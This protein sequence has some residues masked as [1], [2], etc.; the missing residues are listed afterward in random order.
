MHRTIAQL[1]ATQHFDAVHADQLWMAQYAVNLPSPLKVLDQHNAVWTIVHRMWQNERSGLRRMVMQQEWRA[2]QRYEGRVCRQFHRVLTVTEEDRRALEILNGKLPITVVP[3]CIDTTTLPRLEPLS[4]ARHMICIGGMFYP[5]NVDGIVWFARNVLPQVWSACPDSRL[6]VVGARPDPALLALA[7]EEPRV[8]VT[9]YVD[10]PTPLLRESAVFIV[11]LRAGGGMRVKI[12]D[13][14]ARGIPI[15]S[16]TI[17]CEGTAVR[18]GENIVI[19]DEPAD[20]AQAVIRF[21]Q[22]PGLRQQ[23]ADRGCAWVN[24]RYHWRKV[25]PMLDTIYPP[26]KSP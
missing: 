4:H 3:I 17:G 12:L 9:G 11:P 23:F 21:I 7:R 14:W 20:F 6:L 2:L 15:V 10:D 13:A 25:Y 24:E 8:Q 16:T 22:D 5:P 19:A 18:P 1:V 26:T